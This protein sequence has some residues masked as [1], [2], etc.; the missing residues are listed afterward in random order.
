M[1]TQVEQPFRSGEG[2]TLTTIEGGFPAKRGV[3]FISLSN[4]GDQA[5]VKFAGQQLSVPLEQLSRAIPPAPPSFLPGW[6]RTQQPP[7]PLSE[8]DIET[9]ITERRQALAKSQERARLASET[10]A[11][12]RQIAQRAG[13]EVADARTTLA[14]LDAH[15]RAD[16][17]AFEEALSLGRKLPER[18]NGHDRHYITDCV[19]AAEAAQ[20]RFDRELADAQA[21]LSDALS[22]VRKAAANVVAA[23]LERE[24]E[25]LR[26][27]EAR[28]GV[29]RAELSAVSGLWLSAEIGPLVVS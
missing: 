7:T 29:L 24:T 12:A 4:G 18:S 23:Q 21:A 28:A 2:L 6:F 25:N 17:R 20:Q 14:A 11:T 9:R 22:A 3:E 19:Q 26:A 8:A 16:Q 1:Q 27:A 5:T 13:R 15:D 10:V